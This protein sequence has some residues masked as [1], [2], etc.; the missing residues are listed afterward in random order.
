MKIAIPFFTKPEPGKK[1]NWIQDTIE[2]VVIA[3]VLALI[4]RAFIVAV[5]WIPTGSMIP[6][7]GIKD[8]IVANKFIYRFR[9]PRRLEI[10]VFKAPRAFENSG[11]D[12]LIKRI[13]GLPGET[14]QLMDGV[15]F[16]NGKHLSEEHPMNRDHDNFGPVLIPEGHYFMMGDNRSESADSRF[17]GYLPRKKLVGPAFLRIWP[18]TKFGV[19]W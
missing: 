17:W 3:L 12:E 8:R 15:V 16:I 1:K 9:E 6:T 14:L 2:T 4:I 18:L 7:L 5:F 11:K 19:I 10:A 13:I